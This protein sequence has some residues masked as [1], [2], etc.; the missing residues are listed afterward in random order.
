MILV[1]YQIVTKRKPISRPYFGSVERLFL[2]FLLVSAK[3][4][5]TTRK[6]FIN[7]KDKALTD[8]PEIYI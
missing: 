6:N 3:I 8:D 4:I 2:F 7:R 5:V 1:F